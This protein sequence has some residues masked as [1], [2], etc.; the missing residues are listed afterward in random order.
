MAVLAAKKAIRSSGKFASLIRAVF[1]VDSLLILLISCRFNLCLSLLS[2]D[3]LVFSFLSE[4]AFF[5]PS[6][7]ELL[8][9]P[10]D[11]K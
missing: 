9:F 3:N 7:L 1:V 5:D 4:E 8:Y 6:I 2:S 11:Q 10:D